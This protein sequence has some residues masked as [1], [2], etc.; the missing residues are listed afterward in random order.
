MTAEL[1]DLLE[2]YWQAVGQPGQIVPDEAAA[3]LVEQGYQVPG[4]DM[5]KLFSSKIKSTLSQSSIVSRGKYGQLRRWYQL[6]GGARVEGVESSELQ[7]ELWVDVT[8]ADWATRERIIQAQSKRA[9][10]LAA[11]ALLLQDWCNENRKPG[12][13]EHQATFSWSHEELR[14]DRDDDNSA[15]A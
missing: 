9:K 10:D 11:A 8:A 15:A 12:Q 2:K 13:P 5:V 7:R 3:W 1:M 4:L 14:S 6:P